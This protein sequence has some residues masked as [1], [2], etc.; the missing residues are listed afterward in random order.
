M[1]SENKNFYDTMNS[2]LSKGE[3]KLEQ[4]Y[5]RLDFIR[6]KDYDFNFMFES[7]WLT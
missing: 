4:K 1:R 3:N 7:L 5:I 2:T 6:L